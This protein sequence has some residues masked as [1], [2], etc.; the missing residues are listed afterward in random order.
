MP[1]VFF[2]TKK[3]ALYFMKEITIA[4]LFLSRV[5]ESN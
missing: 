4:N 1:M 2:F 5:T 3:Y